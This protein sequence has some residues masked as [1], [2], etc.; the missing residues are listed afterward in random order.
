MDYG[1]SREAGQ[2]FVEDSRELFEYSYSGARSNTDAPTGHVFGRVICHVDYV[3]E[4]NAY[5]H[6]RTCLSVR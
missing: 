5:F 6:D 2:A 1:A 3:I 4:M